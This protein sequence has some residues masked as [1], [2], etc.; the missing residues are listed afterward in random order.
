MVLQHCIIT[1]T[2]KYELK[3]L[4]YKFFVAI[5][6]KHNTAQACTYVYTHFHPGMRFLR[7]SHIA[8]RQ[9]FPN[10]SHN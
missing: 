1:I 5:A 7:T 2:I 10:T 6:S 3:N 9:N 8:P 4:E